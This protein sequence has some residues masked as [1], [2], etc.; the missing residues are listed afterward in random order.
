MPTRAPDFTAEFGANAPF[1]AELFGRWKKDPATVGDDWR[2]F[3]Q[4]LDAGDGEARLDSPVKTQP[5]R[6][7]ESVSAAPP[8]PAPPSPPPRTEGTAAAAVPSSRSEPIRGVA[9]RIVRNMEQSLEIPTATS[10]RSLSVKILEE[11]RNVLNR[12]L[13]VAG[14]AK[15]SYTHL[16]AFAIARAVREMPRLNAAFAE[17]EGHPTRV[18]YERVNLGLA[19]DLESP[20]GSRTLVV[21]NV[22]D[23]GSLDFDAFFR[24]YHDLVTRARAGR[25]LPDDF[26]RTT[27]TL[28][29]PGTLG[30]FAS[31]P[32]LMAGQG[33]IIA[34]GAIAYPPEFQSCSP[35]VLSQLG[36]SRTLTVTST[37]DHRI[38]QGAESGILLKR[39]DDLLQGED[40]FYED[41][42]ASMD[43]PHAP[44]AKAQDRQEIG[45]QAGGA[46]PVEAIEKQ[47]SVLRLIRAYRE[48]GALIADLDPLEFK[49]QG[50]ADLDLG[51]YG[52]TVWDLDRTFMTGGLGGKPRATL[53]EILEILLDTYSRRIGVEHLHVPDPAQRAWI[54]QRIEPSRNLEPFGA[55][56]QR[57][58]LAKLNAAEAFEKFLHTRYV[59]HKRFS[60]EGAETMIPMLDDLLNRAVDNGITRVVMGMA[61]RGR[62]NVLVNT[63]GKSYERVFSE[64]EGLVDPTSVE[65]SGDVK[66]HLGAEGEHVDARR[67]PPAGD[68]RVEPEPPR[69]GEPGRRGHG[70]RAA[71]SPGWDR[72][73]HDSP[74]PHPRRRGVR[75]PGRG[76]GN[77]RDVT[78][79]GLPHGGHRSHRDQQPDRLHRGPGRDALDALVHRSGEERRG[80]RP[81]RERRL[82]R[83]RPPRDPGGVRLPPAV[84][85]GRR[86]GRR[87]LP[88][89]GPQRDRRARVHA[90]APLPEDPRPSVGPRAVRAPPRHPRP[91]DG[92]RAARVRRGL[93]ARAQGR[94]GLVQ[95]A[96]APPQP[97]RTQV[98]DPG[99]AKPE[100][101]TVV[102]VPDPDPRDEA[103]EDE[104]PAPVPPDVLERC[105]AVAVE[106]PAGFVTHPNLARQLAKRLEM[107][108]GR[109]PV[110]W[111]CAEA[112]ALGSLLLEGTPVRLAGQDSA[113]G[114]F[115]QRHAILVDQETGSRY[116]PLSHL[117]PG[118]APF[119]VVNSL[120][121]EE[122]AVGFEFGYAVA[123]PETF[124]LWEAQFGD[125]CNGA[126]IQIDQFLAASEAKWDQLS[127]VTLLLPHG[128][129]GQGPEHSSA[130]LERF[131]QL[132]ALGNM[133][134]ANPSTAAQYFHALRRHGRTPERR[135]LVLMTPKSLLKKREA[136]SPV[137]ALSGGRF[138]PVL[139][140][141][142][143]AAAPARRILLCSGKV[144]YDIRAF[145]AEK[146]IGDVAVI[147]VE[148]LYPLPRRALL[149]AIDRHGGVGR[150][151]GWVQE[152]PRNMGAW[153][154]IEPRLIAMGCEPFYAGR[155]AAASPATGSMT[156]HQA[157]QAAL[158][159]RAFAPLP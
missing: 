150:E 89:L 115:S 78:A 49:P 38:I 108:A 39:I 148:Q 2:E 151:I 104:A 82:P 22:K 70:P 27:L 95:D 143:P 75:R 56:E 98:G 130:R 52:L 19:I 60:L 54:Q 94:A 92:G 100:A 105:V 156:A 129:D 136:A 138:E 40:R 119:T 63:L 76:R 8:S 90:A 16:I 48:L 25:L 159:Q 43:C 122:A 111:G 126:Q 66:Y 57:R 18:F 88:A 65:G 10:V 32:R 67:P 144:A 47:A 134:V 21:P 106:P 55:E 153:S 141:D 128:Y 99:P 113:R 62:L 132:C 13:A 158:V 28:T 34:T 6:G 42:F 155:P 142:L 85:R 137:A 5:P 26:Q 102:V 29:N 64:F 103:Q 96:G 146:K 114:T 131:L 140:D 17:V 31:V 101:P 93:L 139:L 58:I 117:D 133:T 51:T 135:P 80:A 116:V 118:Q 109:E 23:A 81:P 73:A 61:H 87:L 74:A 7:D 84:R 35:E 45:I 149:E 152:E 46:A 69:G 53:R 50:P 112:M 77:A 37:Y 44:F 120:L 24:A 30:T 14:L 123:A 125:F 124:V 71:G 154:W 68:A 86:R 11:N 110:D 4:R 20:D 3:F 12:H 107:A 121:S 91:D 145:R 33:L 79:R 127:G 97:A 1:V 41:V 147:R 72:C 15:A 36:I 157:E 83:V 9:A 59:G